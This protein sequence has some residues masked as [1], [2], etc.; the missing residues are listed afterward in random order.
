VYLVGPI[1]LIMQWLS[2]CCS[3]EKLSTTHTHTHVRMHT[4]DSVTWK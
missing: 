4:E 3:D 2:M 1:L